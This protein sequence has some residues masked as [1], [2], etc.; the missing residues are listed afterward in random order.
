MKKALIATLKVAVPLALGLWLVV[1]F[2]R[3]LDEKQKEELFLAFRQANWW[4]LGLTVLIGWSSHLVRAWRWRY[5][6]DH[7]GHRVSLWNAYNATMSGYFMNMVLPR[8]GEA[9]R[10]VMLYRAEKVPFEKGFGTIMAERAVDM[11]LLLSIAALT[12]LLQIEKIDL[13][14]ERI[15]LFRSEQKVDQSGNAM[16]WIAAA[17]V[18]VILLAGWL[19]ITRPVIRQRLLATASGFM[20]GLR[21]VIQT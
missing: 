2:Y 4:W 5:L 8:A 20:A 7:L 16:V 1:F 12:V 19:I 3:Q 17:A 10:A 21:S 11:I 15:D 13:F 9:T 14:R 18:T 6:L